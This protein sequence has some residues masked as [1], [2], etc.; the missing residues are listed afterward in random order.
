MRARGYARRSHVSNHL[1]RPDDIPALH[2][3]GTQVHQQ[4]GDPVAVIHRHA[5]AVIREPL[6]L[7]PH[8]NH[9]AVRGGRH[10][11]T[12][13][14]AVVDPAVKVPLSR[15]AVVRARFTVLGGD[16]PAAGPQEAAAR[17][18]RKEADGRRGT[19]R[20]VHFLALVRAAALE[21]VGLVVVEP[22]AAVKVPFKILA[23]FFFLN[24]CEKQRKTNKPLGVERTL[25]DANLH[26]ARPMPTVFD[27][28]V[29]HASARLV[30]RG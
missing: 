2:R 5:R 3:A 20:A 1:P 17:E 8:E 10:G 22:D 27:S 9:A 25:P 11:R 15:H 29:K 21:K 19:Q 18:A 6:G 12:L 14:G 28:N 24:G 7:L 4:A 13:R 26:R 16:G 23:I 30:E